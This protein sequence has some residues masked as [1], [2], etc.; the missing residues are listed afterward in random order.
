MKGFFKDWKFVFL[1]AILSL[2]ILFFSVLYQQQ[3]KTFVEGWSRELIITEINDQK[4]SDLMNV[5]TTKVIPI[6]DEKLFLSIWY[7]HQTLHYSTIDTAGNILSTRK[8]DTTISGSNKLE[9]LRDHDRID[10]YNL[11]AKQLS[12]YTFNWR[13]GEFIEQSLLSKGVHDVSAVADGAAYG[14]ENN[15]EFITKGSVFPLGSDGSIISLD[16]FNDG[17]QSLYHLAYVEEKDGLRFL[18]YGTYDS[19]DNSFKSYTLD[20]LPSQS[21]ISISQID[22]ALYKDAVHI[23]VSSTNIKSAKAP[24]VNYYRFGLSQPDKI[25]VYPLSIN[26]F[27][28]N[29]KIINV[30]EKQLSFIASEDI[31]KGSNTEATNLVYYTVHNNEVLDKQLL[32]NTDDLS[33]NPEYFE[34]DGHK[35]MYW[36]HVVGDSK[37]LLLASD[38]PSIVNNASKLKGDEWVK[39]FADTLIGLIPI[40]FIS[41][42]PF[43]Y[44]FLPICLLLFFMS[45]FRLTWM[46]N[47]T[48]KVLRIAIGLHVLIKIYYTLTNFSKNAPMYNSMPAFLQNPVS[49]F[50]IILALTL[51]AL[52]CTIEHMRKKGTS[53]FFMSYTFFAAIDVLLYSLLFLPYY[54]T[55]LILSY[56]TKVG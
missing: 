43:M 1:L 54:Y 20:R 14:S 44:M 36:T 40:T 37:N 32:T 33:L 50:I 46:E 3:V 42:I 39:L 29:P 22:I 48:L 41:L 49:M 53:H 35:Y 12:R 18:K 56:F 6:P 38:H 10:L 55:N 5:K 23:I 31:M 47:N 15:L 30:E 16:A 11:D 51:V 17:I 25:S 45:I 19:S 9:A 2:Y 7:E 34:L 27:A 4:A 13:T 26:S 24:V 8:L 28:P 52:Y 21:T